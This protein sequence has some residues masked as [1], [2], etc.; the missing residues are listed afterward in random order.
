MEPVGGF[1]KANHNHVFLS[2]S[3]SF[4]FLFLRQCMCLKNIRTF[5]QACRRHF[6]LKE[7]DL[8]DPQMLYDYSDFGR[9]LHTLSKLSKCPKAVASGRECVFKNKLLFCDLQPLWRLS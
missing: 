2:L 6:D 3:K 5:L 4:F 8:F 1:E 9:V 7:T